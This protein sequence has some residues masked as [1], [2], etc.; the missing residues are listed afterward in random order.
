[1]SASIRVDKKSYMRLLAMK[2]KLE[3]QRHRRVAIGEAVAE[4]LKRHDSKQK[5]E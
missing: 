4:L 1:M 3:A 2:H 5:E